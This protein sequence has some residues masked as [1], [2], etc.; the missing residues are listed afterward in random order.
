MG[1]NAGAPLNYLPAFKAWWV[2]RKTS[3]L[4]Y[5]GP[6]AAWVLMDQRE[7]AWNGTAA[8]DT[9]MKGY[10]DNQ[11]LMEF[12]LDY[13]GL[14]HSGGASLSFADGHTELK[15]WVDPRTRAPLDLA[16][17]QP[18]DSQPNNPDIYWIEDHATRRK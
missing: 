16:P 18:P 4:N 15:H 17:S 13:P 10:P 12:Y 2:F 9:D 14:Q 7:D 11:E 5:I 6:S 3:D 1:G 8:F